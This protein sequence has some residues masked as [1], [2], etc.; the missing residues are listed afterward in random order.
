MLAR[1]EGGLIVNVACAGGLRPWPKH[2]AYSVS[3]AGV[4]MLTQCLARALAPRVRCNAILPGPVLLPDRYDEKQA[5]RAVV[6]TAL[7]RQGSPEDVVRAILF[8]WDSDY[9][10]GASIPVEGGRLLM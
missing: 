2:L 1:D 9:T 4:L 3:K 7:K 5:H 8:C 10:T 6:K